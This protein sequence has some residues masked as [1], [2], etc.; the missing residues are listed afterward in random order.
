MP[1]IA[2]RSGDTRRLGIV[3]VPEP[4]ASPEKL[5]QQLAEIEGVTPAPNS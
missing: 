4:G 2:V 3:S 1:R 5:Q